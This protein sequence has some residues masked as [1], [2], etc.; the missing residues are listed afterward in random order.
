MLFLADASVCRQN[1][2]PGT[3]DHGSGCIVHRPFELGAIELRGR[4][5]RGD[6]EKDQGQKCGLRQSEE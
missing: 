1:L 4:S 2:H 3:P 6:G 5:Y